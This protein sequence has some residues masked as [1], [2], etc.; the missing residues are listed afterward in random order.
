[1]NLT[2]IMNAVTSKTGRMGLIIQKRSPELLMAV[3]VIGVVTSTVLA[4]RATLKVEEILDD[5]KT[6]IDKINFGHETMD[7]EVYSDTDYKKDLAVTYVKTGVDLVKLYGPSVLLGVASIGCIIGSHKILHGRNVALVAA[8]KAVEQGFADYRKRVIADIGDEADRFFKNG[9]I[10][11]DVTNINDGTESVIET[12]NPSEIS[13]YAR[14]FDEAAPSWSKNPEY[15]MVF[16]ITHQNY[17]NDMFKANGHL[18][19][20]EVYDMLE[21]PRSSAGQIVGWVKGY[22]DQFVDFG[23]FNGTRE[24][25]RHFVNGE[26]CSILL[27]FNVTGIVYDMI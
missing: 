26:E 16:L 20:N 8:Y 22:G 6:K 21:L 11:H 24:P 13:Q 18:F 3:G 25:V 12:F 9:I 17:A 14:F 10:K 27:D 5:A 7:K 23:I 15:N 4:C 19:L 2:S 1:M